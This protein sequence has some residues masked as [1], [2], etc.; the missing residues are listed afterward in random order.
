MT[1]VVLA[2]ELRLRILE[3][4]RAAF[5]KECCGLLEGIRAEDAFRIAAL[6]PAHNL[7]T[8][9][10]RFEI[11]PEDHIKAL[12]T[13]RAHGRRIVGCYHSHPDGRAE[14]SATDEAGAGEEEFVWLIAA[15]DRLAGFVYRRGQFSG[16]DLSSPGCAW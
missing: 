9:P 13:A 2:D 11:A 7:A 10:D 8:R 4:A 12:K 3:E 1:R 15:G 5:P 14:P 16:A 6:H